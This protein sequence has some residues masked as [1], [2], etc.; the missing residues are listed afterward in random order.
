MKHEFLRHRDIILFG[1]QS[2]DTD[3]GSNFKDMALELS[4]NNRVL[5]VNRALDRGFKMKNKHTPEV[6]SRLQAIRTGK[7]EIM[8]VAPNLWVQN[9]RTILESINWIPSAWLHD[10]LNKVNNKR[11][12][13]QIGKMSSRLKFKNVILINDNDFIRGRYLKKL[14]NCESYIFYIRD[15]MLGVSF[16]ERHGPRLESG[17]MR[18]ADLIVANSTYLANYSRQFNPKSFDIGQGCDLK[19]Y[20]IENPPIP[21]DL[22]P[23][24]KPVIGYVGFISA[25]RID[26]QVVKYLAEQ[27]PSYSIVLVGPNDLKSDAE[28]LQKLPNLH[29]L[30]RKPQEALSNYIHYFDVCINPQV[31]NDI[32]IG[33]YPRKVDEYLAM[34]KPV[35]ATRTEAMKLFEPYTWLCERKEDYVKQIRYILLHPEE[36]MSAAEQERRKAFA[37]SHTWEDSIGRLGAAYYEAKKMF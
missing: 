8:E 14:L 33:N 35:V 4:K 9:P 31:L 30:G 32:T 3:I 6:K 28:T 34:G 19:H 12:A 15:Y 36:T 10:M 26:I 25:W 18:E 13:R 5:Y 1:F 20:T 16:F 7:G 27:L 2:W 17:T 11:L 21:E 37:F 29:F 23:L 22:A 24:K